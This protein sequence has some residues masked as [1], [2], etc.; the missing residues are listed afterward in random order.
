[1]KASWQVRDASISEWLDADTMDP[2]DLQRNLRDIR[3]INAVLG[4]TAFTTRAVLGSLRAQPQRVWSLLDVASGSA[5]IP[6]AIARAA[7]RAG[8]NL[9]VTATDRN[10]QIVAVARTQSAGIAQMTVEA[11][12]ALA[13]PYPDG[14]FDIA[15]CT[16]ALHHFAPDVAV[17]LLRSMARVGQRVMVYD[18]VRSPLAYAGVVA[19][20]RLGRMHAMTCHDGPASVRRAYSAAEVRALAAE[21]GLLHAQV[22]VGFP[23]RLML[24]ADGTASAPGGSHAL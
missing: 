5:D 10:P 11:Q 17:L 15:L 1:M 23:F 18:V 7:L 2:R 12:D 20:T 4:W 3:H 8:V 6:I 13:L 14:S 16:L 21:A 24:T 9:R 19:M 22:C